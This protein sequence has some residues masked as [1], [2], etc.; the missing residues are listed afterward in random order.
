MSGKKSQGVRCD[1]T[2]SGPIE[3]RHS[4]IDN[5]LVL[6]Q[7]PPIQDAARLHPRNRF[8]YAEWV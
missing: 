1:A 3:N 6:T 8:Q 5:V 4:K 2:G 7:N